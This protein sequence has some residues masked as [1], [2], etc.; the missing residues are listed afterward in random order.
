MDSP[1]SRQD[2][3]ITAELRTMLGV[4][5]VLRE[6]Q[7]TVVRANS[8]AR[9]SP[10][11]LDGQHRLGRFVWEIASQSLGVA[12]DHLEAWRRLIEEAHTQPGWAHMTLLRGAIESASLCRWLID[13]TAKY[14][15]AWARIMHHAPQYRSISSSFWR[16]CRR[17]ST[18]F[19]AGIASPFRLS[20]GREARYA[21]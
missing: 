10:A 8:K 5:P 2:P 9:G 16:V 6:R 17:C 21:G 15:R 20:A 12:G 11:D 3:R 7:E 18:T 19:S 1:A 4:V 13:P 14:R